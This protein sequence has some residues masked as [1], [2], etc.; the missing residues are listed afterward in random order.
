MLNVPSR[1]DPSGA[2]WRVGVAILLASLLGS[3]F[4]IFPTKHT[5]TASVVKEPQSERDVFYTSHVAPVLRE[6]C[7][8]CHGG[9]NHRGGLSMSSRESL[10]KGGKSGP[11]I[12]AGHP[13]Q[14][15]LIKLVLQEN[16]TADQRPMPLKGKLSAADIST[17][18]E[19]IRTGATMP[20]LR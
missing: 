17:L 10:L 8:R 1:R 14:S 4:W 19:W 13:E 7:L 9:L 11:A 6:N 16:L 2:K 15:L 3:I 5:I 20:A 18:E 12:V